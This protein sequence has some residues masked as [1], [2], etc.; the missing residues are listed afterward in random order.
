M[1]IDDVQAKREFTAEAEELLEALSEGISELDAQGS[2]VRP[3]VVNRIF[4]EIHSLKG[5]AGML[6]LTEIADLSHNLEDM[7][8]RLRMGRLEIN[9]ALTDLLFDSVDGLNRLVIAIND[10]E[11]GELV[12]S[13]N[14]LSRIH[15]M[16]KS[17][18][19]ADLDDPLEDLDLD[20]Q[21]R[22]SLTEYEEHRLSTNVREGKNIFALS[23]SFPFA[24]FDEEL[25][26]ISE[27]MSQTGEMISTLPSADPT[28]G[29]RIAFRLLYATT[30]S[31]AEL[32]Q[33]FP[34]GEVASLGEEKSVA[35]ESGGGGEE[36]VSLR[37]VGHSV[38][39][40]IGRLDNVLNIV[41][42]LLRERTRL[43]QLSRSEDARENRA[44]GQELSRVSRS[45]DRRLG[46]L[47]RSVV[48][49]RMVP[50]GQIFSKLSRAVRKVARELGKPIE[51]SLRG[52]E[53]ELDKVMVEELADPLLHIIRNAI[54][55]GIEPAEQRLAAGKPEAGQITLSAY[56]LGNSVVIDIV[57]DGSGVD[58]EKVRQTAIRKGIIGSEDEL[59]E[60]ETIDL[61]FAA[62]FST[63]SEVSEI[64]GRGV[65]LDVVRR[66][67]TELKGSIE[68][69]TREG[70][71]T[72][73]RVTLPITLA[74]IKALIV[75]S[76]GTTYAVPLTSVEE[77]VRIW[78]RDFSRLEGREVY[79]LRERTIPMIRLAD[80]FDLEDE[81][82][83]DDEKW[84]MIVTRSGDRTSGLLVDRII[85]QYEIVIK[86]VGERLKSVPGVAGATEVGDDEVVL[87]I[88]TESLISAFGDRARRARKEKAS[89]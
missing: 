18:S 87:V 46:E 7:L 54:D 19:V 48:D 42:E 26:N 61:L 81:R 72:T 67:L 17:E 84:F 77:I 41:G 5:L 4:R 55:H 23:V 43:D 78:G 24:T 2:A 13:S 79:R 65:G 75:E 38:R 47:Q 33:Q 40:D 82:D 51:L 27:R 80:A 35:P 8:D 59:S 64:S 74:I 1:S 15:K 53:T 32:S 16:L 12:D 52:E 44:F 31:T 76:A 45:I 14:L 6:G 83:G 68:V 60:R 29:D 3:D 58:L 39:V 86:S 37:S 70:T 25:R 20:D 28:A 57:D 34:E 9:A 73:F 30:L 49:M 69:N 89:S 36:S 62:G 63:A 22:A 11:V 50:V 66:N 88:D 71:G 21:T 10:P 56:Q 85:G